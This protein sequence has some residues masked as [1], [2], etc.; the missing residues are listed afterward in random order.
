MPRVKK[1][2]TTERT[3]GVSTTISERADEF[4]KREAAKEDRSKAAILRRALERYA[5]RQRSVAA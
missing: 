3:V 1:P 2:E 5:K 4:F